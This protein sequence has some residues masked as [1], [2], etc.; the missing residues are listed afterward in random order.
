MKCSILG[1]FGPSSFVNASHLTLDWSNAFSFSEPGF[2]YYEV[3][4]GAIEGAGGTIPG[5]MTKET[6]HTFSRGKIVA[7]TPYFVTIKAISLAAKYIVKTGTV[8]AN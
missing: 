6:T 1:D 7:G 8:T 2:L 3:F 4:A 5:L